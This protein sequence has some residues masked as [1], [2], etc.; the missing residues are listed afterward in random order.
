MSSVIERT[1]H[2]GI[3]PRQVLANKESLP[4]RTSVFRVAP[5]VL[6]DNNASDTHTVI[7][8]NG[9]DRPGFLSD[10]TYTLY[11][12]NV[13]ISSARIATYGERAVDVF[14]IRDLFGH[15]ITHKS[16]I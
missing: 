11:R 6:V 12:L 7:E 14:Y 9:R 8:I 4:P 5:Q 16:R 10:L 1:L 2:G 13:S 15:K 3:K